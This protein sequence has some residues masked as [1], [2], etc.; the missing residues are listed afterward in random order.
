[1]DN[2]NNINYNNSIITN[3]SKPQSEISAPTDWF[4]KTIRGLVRMYFGTECKQAK[5]II[6]NSVLDR[7]RKKDYHFVGEIR[8]NIDSLASNLSLEIIRQSFYDMLHNKTQQDLMVKKGIATRQQLDQ[9][10]NDYPQGEMYHYEVYNSQVYCDK[11]REHIV[12]YF[13]ANENEKVRL[14][15]NVLDVVKNHD[16]SAE[17]NYGLKRT[18]SK[19]R[20]CIR[21]AFVKMKKIMT[22][23]K[24]RR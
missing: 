3:P 4:N 22:F 21:S 10:I 20:K 17:C 7:I 15:Q 24:R 2:I 18:D 19:I 23:K 12:E 8:I 16:F 1:M 5:N 11:I 13:E 9:W 6:I 14:T